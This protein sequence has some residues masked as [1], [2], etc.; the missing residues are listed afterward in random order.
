MIWKIS[1]KYT[2]CL[3]VSMITFVMRLKGSCKQYSVPSQVMQELSSRG[4]RG[5]RWS[6]DKAVDDYVHKLEADYGDN[7]SDSVLGYIAGLMR[8]ISNARER[9]NDQKIHGRFEKEPRPT[10]D[11]Y[12]LRTRVSLRVSGTRA[13]KEQSFLLPTKVLS[14][15]FR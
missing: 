10:M 9:H 2:H 3:L 13:S 1:R 5:V 11:D 12:L 14:L 4:I 8:Q 6:D 15:G 7:F